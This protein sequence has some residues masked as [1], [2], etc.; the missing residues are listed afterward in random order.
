[1]PGTYSTEEIQK[2]I[3][4]FL[5]AAAVDFKSPS[6]RALFYNDRTGILMV[7][8]PLQELESV[9]SA[10]EVLNYSPP[11]VTI[12]VKVC[13]LTEEDEA[14]LGF[15][16]FLGNSV[17]P[18]TNSPSTNTVLGT[19]TGI[20]T[21]P[22]FRVVIRALEQRGDTNLL[23]APRVTTL[24]GRQAQ[25]KVTNVKAVVTGVNYQT[26]KIKGPQGTKEEVLANYTT[27]DMDFGPTVDVT[28]TVSTNGWSIQMNVNVQVNEFLGYDAPPKT[29]PKDAKGQEPLPRYRVR[30][31]ASNP[32]VWD[33]QTIV[34]SGGSI[35]ENPN[36]GETKVRA[37]GDLPLLGRFF[38]SGSAARNRKN[39]V[40]FV[41][42]TIIDPAGNPIHAIPTLRDLPF[43]PL[44]IPPQAPA[45]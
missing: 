13:E 16:W 4:D 15:D 17:V 42:P 37:L 11:Q 34:L 41:T 29:D 25:I 1:M 43:D 22:Q 5:T 24:G 45:K 36:K 44:S 40:I 32:I 38:R 7:R 20:L 21:D 19:R 12:E 31:L 23:A 10:I 30:Q 8:A 2:A 33:G 6:S 18:T 39:L 14:A 9:A 28:P 26:N 35:T 27:S 3:R